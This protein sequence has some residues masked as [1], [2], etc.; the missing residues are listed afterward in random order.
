ME[1]YKFSTEVPEDKGTREGLIEALKGISKTE[2]FSVLNNLEINDKNLELMNTMASIQQEMG[3]REIVF[4]KDADTGEIKK[5]TNEF[6]QLKKDTLKETR[7]ELTKPSKFIRNSVIT[8]VVAIGLYVDQSQYGP[9]SQAII[10]IEALEVAE[11]C[12][13][14]AAAGATLVEIGFAVKQEI[15]SRIVANNKI[16]RIL[17]MIGLGMKKEEAQGVVR[18]ETRKD[19]KDSLNPVSTR[20]AQNFGYDVAG[21]SG[22]YGQFSKEDIERVALVRKTLDEMGIKRVSREKN[23][24]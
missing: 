24:G 7:K 23:Q 21:K 22:P 11:F 5:G 10:N 3:K 15:K 2:A 19:I 4:K 20:S 8:A 9:I 12:A 6:A 16:Q 17:G 13:M 1:Q 14:F 18:T